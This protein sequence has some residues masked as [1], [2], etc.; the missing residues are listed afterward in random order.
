LSRKEALRALEAQLGARAPRGVAALTARE[1]QDLADA[2]RQARHEQAT[3][4][5]AAG[6]RALGHIPWL[7][8]KPIQK[9]MGA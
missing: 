2:V 1:L 6:E 4:L 9:V 5:Q 7:L 3:E 8:R